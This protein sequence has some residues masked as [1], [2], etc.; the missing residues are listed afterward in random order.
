[1]CAMIVCAAFFLILI[2]KKCFAQ[3]D[4]ETQEPELCVLQIENPTRAQS[5]FE[6]ESDN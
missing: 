6:S 2:P 5:Y 1:M 4:A 3:I